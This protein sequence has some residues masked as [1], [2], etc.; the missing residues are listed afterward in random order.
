MFD[1][2]RPDLN[3]YALPLLALLVLAMAWGRALPSWGRRAVS[4]ALR[5]AVL[6]LCLL[7]LALALALPEVR[8]D[9]QEEK[10][11][12]LLLDVSESLPRA[13]RE[14]AVSEAQEVLDALGHLP[15]SRRSPPSSASSAL[16]TGAACIGMIGSRKRVELTFR[17]LQRTGLA[18]A[19]PRMHAPI[20]LKMGDRTPGEVALAILAELIQLRGAAP[21]ATPVRARETRGPVV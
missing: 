2:A 4:W 10:A 17:D 13:E 18:A 3:V 5:S 16:A 12:I 11:R 19:D 1:F 8:R 6:L 7:A 15:P 14:G 20:G 9:I 21:V